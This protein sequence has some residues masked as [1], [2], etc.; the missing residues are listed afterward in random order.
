MNLDT[1]LITV[2]VVA[3]SHIPDRVSEL[4][5]NLLNQLSDR[6]VDLI[7]HAGDICV[8]R[9]MDQLIE[10]APVRA[11]RGNR[12]FLFSGKLPSILHFELGGVRIL[13]AHGHGNWTN[14]LWDKVI[15]FTKGYSLERYRNYLVNLDPE[16]KVIIFGH[17][18]FSEN[19]WIH[20]KL[21]FN[22]GSCTTAVQG[23]SP[24]YGILRFYQGSIVEGEIIELDQDLGK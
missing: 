6:S 15:M 24:T 2:G 14:Y 13:L 21:I 9:V 18:H 23:R 22:P 19:C 16:A 4:P 10:I 5:K 8:P 20:D 1:P 7:L 3:D 17:T 11:V 12:D